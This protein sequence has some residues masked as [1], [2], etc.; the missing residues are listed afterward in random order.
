M[1]WED[2]IVADVRKIREDLS[3]QFNY[4]LEAVFADIRARQVTLGSQLV[5]ATSGEAERSDA[6][7]REKAC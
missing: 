6:A 1:T 7:E 5:K 4:D 2:P 3:A